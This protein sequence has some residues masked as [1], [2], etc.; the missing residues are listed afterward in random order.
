MQIKMNNFGLK[1]KINYFMY[2]NSQI[3]DKDLI[4]TNEDT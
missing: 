4:T 2:F 1:K 3:K